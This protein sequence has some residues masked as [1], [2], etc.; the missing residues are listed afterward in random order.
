MGF[1]WMLFFSHVFANHKVVGKSQS[2]TWAFTS[3]PDKLQSVQSN[4]ITSHHELFRLYYQYLEEYE[5]TGMVATVPRIEHELQ[6]KRL[7]CYPGSSEAVRR[8][9]FAYLTPQYIQPSPQLVVSKKTAETLLR[10]GVKS[11]RL[12]DILDNRGLNGVIG[13]G[14]SFGPSID[15]ILG[16]KNQNLNVMLIETFGTSALKMIRSR[17]VSYTIEYPFIVKALTENNQEL[18]DLVT[19]PLSDVDTVMIQYLACSKTP[20]G[21]EVIRRADEIIRRNIANPSYW[22]GVLETAP[23]ES[24]KSLQKEI[25]KYIIE[26]R[27]APVI[28]E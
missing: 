11:V 15:K 23:P 12:A 20:E 2:I 3:A 6:K 22:V 7:V 16:E 9:E 10:G 4:L 24:K 14:R 8:R 18:S 26:R 21:L 25:D 1:F 17:R 13:K 28:I 27:K 19:I 5:H